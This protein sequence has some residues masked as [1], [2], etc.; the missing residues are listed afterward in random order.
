MTGPVQEDMDDRR[1]KVE[2]LAEAI[3]TDRRKVD[4]VMS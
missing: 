1:K 4:S 2:R 3:E